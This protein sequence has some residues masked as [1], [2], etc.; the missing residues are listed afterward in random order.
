MIRPARWTSLAAILALSACSGPADEAGSTASASPER[1]DA[2][3]TTA[4]RPSAIASLLDCAREEG[5]TLVSAHRGGAAPGIA[6]NS[7]AAIRHAAET[8]AAFAEIDLARTADGA[9]V[10][11]HD[12]TLDRTTT[13]SGP[14][15]SHYLSELRSFSLVGPDGQ[16]TGESIPTLDEAFA[17]ALEA[18]IFLQ[19][20]HKAIPAAEAAR[21]ARDV[22]Q[23]N[24]TL[25]I[26]YSIDTARAARQ[27][28]PQIGLSLGAE[29]PGALQATGLDTTT[30]FAWLGGG[31]PPAT[32]DADFAGIGV[33]TGAHAFREEETGSA[34]Y[35][36]WRAAG[37]EVLAVDDVAAATSV[38]GRARDHCP[39]AFR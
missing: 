31:V 25:V 32:F 21:V 22:G 20:D 15:S 27:A 38:L 19:L 5:V 18:G 30:M 4:R 26:A 37:V 36:R 9:I 2:S 3:I 34:D 17:V 10:L 29:T 13:G 8:G 14:V 24:R 1:G 28:A 39:A 33:E 6:E 35:Q 7:L 11:M 23:D 12:E 16:E